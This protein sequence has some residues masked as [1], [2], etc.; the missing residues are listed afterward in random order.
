MPDP[1]SDPSKKP[2]V[3]PFEVVKVTSD[4][5]ISFTLRGVIV[6]LLALAGTGGVSSLLANYGL[7]SNSSVEDVSKKQ[8]VHDKLDAERHVKVDE[9]LKGHDTELQGIT[10]TIG[11]VQEVQHW[12]A[13]DQAAERVSQ[14]APKPRR[15]EAYKRL[16]RSNMKRLKGKELPCSNLDCTN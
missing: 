2:S 11:E 15:R 8:V 1:I 5:K 14:A 3:P 12:Q 7:A 16:F 10:A 6:I 9:R 13:A 4:G